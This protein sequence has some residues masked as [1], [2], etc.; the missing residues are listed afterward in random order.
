MRRPLGLQPR[1]SATPTL[2][3]SKLIPTHFRSQRPTRSCCPELCSGER[4]ATSSGC[5]GPPFERPVFIH[6]AR[7]REQRFN[8]PRPLRLYADLGGTRSESSVRTRS[9]GWKRG[10]R[11]LECESPPR[12]STHLPPRRPLLVA[13]LRAQLLRSWASFTPQVKRESSFFHF[14]RNFFPARNGSGKERLS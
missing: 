3:A 4:K 1:D 12:T 2:A 10:P 13:N 9:D 7:Y 14:T 5:A 6:L 8:K 11:P